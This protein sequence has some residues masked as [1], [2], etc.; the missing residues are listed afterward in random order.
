MPRY[1]GI[2]ARRDLPSPS[3]PPRYP[4]TQ[5][6]VWSSWVFGVTP[7]FIPYRSQDRASQSNAMMMLLGCVVMILLSCSAGF[8]LGWW[9]RGG[10]PPS[11]PR[12]GPPPSQRQPQRLLRRGHFSEADI[13]PPKDACFWDYVPDN[14]SP[15]SSGCS[16]DSAKLR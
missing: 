11:Q 8:V 4:G 9:W 15:P 12:G 10:S 7:S 5:A 16:W 6:Q 1:L 13:E 14:L 2:C 3:P